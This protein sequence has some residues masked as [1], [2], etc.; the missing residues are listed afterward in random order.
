MVCEA[1][2]PG[3]LSA[4]PCVPTLH[5][6]PHLAPLPCIRAL[7]CV[8]S[9]HPCPHLAPLPCIRALPCVP[10]LHSCPHLASLPCVPAPDLPTASSPTPPPTLPQPLSSHPRPRRH[11]HCTG[12]RYVVDAG[13]SKQKLLEDTSGGQMARLARAAVG[14]WGWWWGLQIPAQFE[15]NPMQTSEKDSAGWGVGGGWAMPGGPRVP[16]VSR[17][18]GM[19][20][21]LGSAATRTRPRSLTA[22]C[23]RTHTSLPA[24]LL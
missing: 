13:R 22:V 5:P 23:A 14:W 10:S 18:G 24:A 17:D 20:Y 12:I 16:R 6:C 3:G 21:A 11:P 19:P 8:P 9:L 15:P 4:G 2:R 7:P 1:C